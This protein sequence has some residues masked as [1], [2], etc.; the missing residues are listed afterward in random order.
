M[1]KVAHKSFDLSKI[2]EKSLKIWAKSQ[3]I[4]AKWR[5]TL[6]D[7]NKWCTAFSEKRMKS[8][9]EV[10]PKTF[11]M[12]FVEERQFVD[13]SRT[14]TSR[15]SWGNFGKNPSQP[16]KIACFYTY[17]NAGMSKFELS[18]K[19]ETR[20]LWADTLKLYSKHTAFNC[21]FY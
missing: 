13:Q 17:V 3:K 11:F 19:D 4:Q 10:T 1:C 8:F 7:F 16:L 5:P 12:I 21:C 14:K 15:A 20:T 2:R 6:F 9:L 18:Q